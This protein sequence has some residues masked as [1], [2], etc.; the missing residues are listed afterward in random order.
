MPKQKQ[1]AERQDVTFDWREIA[2]RID[3]VVY[4]NP[5]AP[6]HYPPST[7]RYWST[8]YCLSGFTGDPQ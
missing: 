6:D 5:V 4:V 1:N 7:D 3:G 8:R 2:L